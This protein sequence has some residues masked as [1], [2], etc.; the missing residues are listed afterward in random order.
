MKNKN[1]TTKPQQNLNTE[2]TFRVRN[3][4]FYWRTNEL[5]SVKWTHLYCMRLDLKVTYQNEGS[6]EI[7]TIGSRFPGEAEGSNVAGRQRGE[8]MYFS[9]GW[10]VLCSAAV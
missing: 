4:H 3:K 1:K 8:S 2:S 6:T 7:W 9:F 5:C 10:T